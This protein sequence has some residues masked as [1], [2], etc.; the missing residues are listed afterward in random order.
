M[1]AQLFP[2]NILWDNYRNEQKPQDHSTS[3]G[4]ES[5]EIVYIASAFPRSM[6]FLTD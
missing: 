5:N 3:W 6:S 1:V 2:N 4:F